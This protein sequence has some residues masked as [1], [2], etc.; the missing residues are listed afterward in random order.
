MQT[1]LTTKQR[2]VLAS[3]PEVT[4]RKSRYSYGI[5]VDKPI[6]NLGDFDAVTDIVGTNPEGEEVVPRM[7]WYL[8][9]VR[10]D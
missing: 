8:S 4:A 3:M 1:Y 2:A 9:K 10:E 5:V 7:D 6:R